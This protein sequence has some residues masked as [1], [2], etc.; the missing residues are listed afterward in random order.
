MS[1]RESADPSQECPADDV[2]LEVIVEVRDDAASKA[3]ESH[4]EQC[5]RCQ[6]RLEELSGTSAVSSSLLQSTIAM[7]NSDEFNRFIS[8][9]EGQGKLSLAGALTEEV[10]QPAPAPIPIPTED[11]SDLLDP[12]S[13]PEL[14][15]M[16]GD[17]EIEEKVAAGG[18]GVVFKARDPALN[19][20]VAIKVL[21]LSKS[22][23]NDA[24]ERFVREAQAAA[25]IDHEN[26]LPIYHVDHGAKSP[27]LVMPFIHGKTLDET[28]RSSDSPLPV[29]KIIAITRQ[30]AGGL[31]AAHDRGLIHRDIKPANLLIEDDTERIWI[32]DFGLARAIWDPSLTTSGSLTGTPLFMSP[33]Q[34]GDAP[35]DARSDLFSLGSVLYY[36]ATARLPFTGA[37]SMSILRKVCDEEPTPVPEINPAIPT[38]LGNLIQ[39]LMQKDPA[40]RPQSAEEALA[41]LDH[42][43]VLTASA[44]AASTKSPRDIARKRRSP[45]MWMAT[46]GA[47]A[48]IAAIGIAIYNSE[49]P[50]QEQQATPASATTANAEPG[51]S[52]VRKNG[53]REP[54]KSLKSA[55]QLVKQ[56]DVIELSQLGDKAFTSAPLRLDR[57]ITLQAAKGHSPVIECAETLFTTASPL[58]LEGLTLRC[59]TPDTTVIHSTRSELSFTN[60]RIEN[61]NKSSGMLRRTRQLTNPVL[62]T[63]LIQCVAV[64]SIIIRNCQLTSETTILR[65]QPEARDRG[66][67]I[68]IR[69]GNSVLQA[70]AGLTIELARNVHIDM[71]RCLTR[72]DRNLFTL[73]RNPRSKQNGECSLSLSSN[74]IISTGPIIGFGNAD[75]ADSTTAEFTTNAWSDPAFWSAHF[76][77]GRRANSSNDSSKFIT[78]NHQAFLD[79]LDAE[80]PDAMIIKNSQLA[81]DNLRSVVKKFPSNRRP[82]IRM[83]GPGN[84]YDSFRKMPLYR[85]GMGAELP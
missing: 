69:I 82:D 67:D 49:K 29:E 78:R 11:Y 66:G 28:I 62:S 25:G 1:Q 85:R 30:I 37:R 56:G 9:I 50:I 61:I 70:P 6:L 52:I 42:P 48:G 7:K 83:L 60:C 64:P 8:R 51:I 21:Q 63:P 27:F 73:H 47:L 46:C 38:W 17:Y 32:A 2:L 39:R 45:S 55:L 24:R 35:I 79:L 12:P 77:P 80:E 33:E 59:T 10:G 13:R 71:R 5:E 41:M 31:A 19:R 14:I 54:A 34:A 16:L 57:A 44:D 75:I 18:M 22:G 84:A 20:T 43:D 81:N 23:M 65:L 74:S 58:H 68:S 3:I 36:M 40:D 4:L 76:L 72:T 53:N 26:I 15:G